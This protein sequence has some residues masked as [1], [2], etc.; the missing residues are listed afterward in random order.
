MRTNR[1]DASTILFYCPALIAIFSLSHVGKQGEPFGLS[2]LIGL[3]CA[4]LPLLLPAIVYILSCFTFL[5]THVFGLY[6]LQGILI[7]GAFFLKEKLFPDKRS[8][9]FLPFS[10]LG[11]MLALFVFFLLSGFTTL[12]VLLIVAGIATLAGGYVV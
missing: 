1:F 4:G 6:A 5:N 7:F 11:A 12:I 2:L 8:G 3:G 9:L 10:V